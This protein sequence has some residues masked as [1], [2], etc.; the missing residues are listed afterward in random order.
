MPLA[1]QALAEPGAGALVVAAAEAETSA[2]VPIGDGAL[3][4]PGTA[5]R[6]VAAALPP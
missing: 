4:E 6:V 1:N 2:W 3:A 5:A